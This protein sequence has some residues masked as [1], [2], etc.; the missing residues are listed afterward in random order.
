VTR[1]RLVLA[2][3]WLGAVA[4]VVLVTMIVAAGASARPASCS[5]PRPLPAVDRGAAPLLLKVANE[6][7]IVMHFGDQGTQAVYPVHLSANAGPLVP[8]DFAGADALGVRIGETYFRKDRTHWIDLNHRDGLEARLIPVGPRDLELCVVV[9]PKAI[10]GLVPGRYTG[11]VFVVHTSD[12]AQLAALPVEL[13]F[14]ASR[15]TAIGI[16]S[17]AVLLGLVV[18]ALSEAAARQRHLHVSATRAL[19][20]YASEL[21]FPVMLIL[22]AIAGW[23]VFRQMYDGNPQWGA[24][25]GDTAKLF[26]VCFIAQMSGNQGIDVIRRVAGAAPAAATPEGTSATTGTP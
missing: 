23:L 16:A 3:T 8:R 13:T 15:W 2:S 1:R 17:L 5:Q 25:G 21:S 12:Q 10:G 22:A 7:A 26:T 11:T 20:D 14:R 18:K 9:H 24:S 4:A 6:E 19:K